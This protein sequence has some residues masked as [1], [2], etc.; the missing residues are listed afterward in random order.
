MINN[1][2]VLKHNEMEMYRDKVTYTACK[3]YSINMNKDLQLLPF[4]NNRNSSYSSLPEDN[5]R[6]LT[7][8]LSQT[9]RTHNQTTPIILCY[10][11]KRKP[12]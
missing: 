3:N 5:F 2:I 8:S 7:Q 6:E 9:Q 4:H 10:Y 1:T 11:I 12:V